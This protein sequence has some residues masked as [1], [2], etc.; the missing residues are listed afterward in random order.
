MNQWERKVQRG[1]FRWSSL[2]QNTID[3]HDN[4][5]LMT[6]RS[7]NCLERIRCGPIV[8]NTGFDDCQTN[9]RTYWNVL[10]RQ[11]SPCL[12]LSICT[13]TLAFAHPG[14]KH[15][16]FCVKI[17]AP[18]MSIGITSRLVFPGM[19]I[20]VHAWSIK[21][22]LVEHTFPRSAKIYNW[23]SSFVELVAPQFGVVYK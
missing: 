21:N 3:A 12:V 5:I 2:S 15:R 18:V 11:G 6:T 14:K 19:L 1:P 7:R 13:W 22:W 9:G 8:N 23:A 20:V 16:L 4:H 10:Q 17:C